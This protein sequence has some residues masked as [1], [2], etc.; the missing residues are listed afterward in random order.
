MRDLAASIEEQRTGQQ[1]EIPGCVKAA[2]DLRRYE[3]LFADVKPAWIVELGTYRGLSATWMA[4]TAG[5]QVVTIDTHPQA[6]VETRSHTS[7]T[8]LTGNS[9]DPNVVEYVRRLVQDQGPVVVVCDSDHS[10]DHVYA[11]MCA[12]S[13]MVTEGAYLCVEDGIV[14]WIPE[15]LAV[16]KDSSP[17]DAIERFLAENPNEWAVDD[18]IENML[19][20]TQHPS[21]WLRRIG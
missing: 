7:V 16:Y 6:D 2:S 5:A 3:R 19:P 9:V 15:Q 11:E 18:A 8:W 1:T 20:T 12:Y 4:D 13:P 14:A 21:G 17:L 10:A